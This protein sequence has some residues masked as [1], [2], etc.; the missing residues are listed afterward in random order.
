MS[1]FLMCGFPASGKTTIANKLSQLFQTDGRKVTIIRDGD[2]AINHTNHQPPTTATA[3]EAPSDSKDGAQ[4]RADWY[5]SAAAEKKSRAQLRTSV[6]RALSDTRAIVLVDSLNYIKGFRYELFCLAKTAGVTYAVIHADSPASV[7]HARDGTR[8]T[9]GDDSY[10]P[11]VLTALISRFEP[12][13]PNTRW[14]SPL[15]PVDVAHAQYDERIAEV[16][17]RLRGGAP[18]VTSMATRQFCAPQ[19]D[20]LGEIDRVTRAAEAALIQHVQGGAAVGDRLPVPG[21]SAVIHL[22]RKPRISELRDMRRAYL[23]FCRMH[24]P[25]AS[26]PAT[27]LDEYLQYMNEQLRSR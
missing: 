13:N 20:V 22:Q 5:A 15:L 11:S 14:D 17:T 25:K 9:R 8:A 16:Y 12:P 23:N 18:L 19:V 3:C 27:M 6:E 4:T 10:G 21:T 7:C 1:L 26:M 24:P 2:A